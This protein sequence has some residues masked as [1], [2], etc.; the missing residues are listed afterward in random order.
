[1]LLRANMLLSMASLVIFM[2]LRVLY[3]QL[4]ARLRRHANYRRILL[5]IQ[6]SCPLVTLNNDSDTSDEDFKCAICW[7]KITLARQLPCCHLFHYG[8]IV[9]SFV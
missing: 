7:E 3:A 9:R 6:S 1:M 2:Q 5:L 4:V 8:I